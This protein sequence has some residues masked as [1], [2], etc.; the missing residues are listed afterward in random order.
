MAL[1]NDAEH[2]PYLG[3]GWPDGAVKW[4]RLLLG[5]YHAD[6]FAL[7]GELQLADALE[8]LLEVG[9]DT[10]RVLGLGQNLQQLVVRQEEKSVIVT[11]S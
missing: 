7:V 6:N 11:T 10:E 9:L 4:H 5:R 8:A 3:F 2:S 1:E